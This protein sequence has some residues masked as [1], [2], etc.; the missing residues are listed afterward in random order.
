MWNP[1]TLPGLVIGATTEI[2]RALLALPGALADLERRLAQVDRLAEQSE[3]MTQL[4]EQTKA[5]AEGIRQLAE[6]ILQGSMATRDMLD[7]TQRELAELNRRLEK[8][9]AEPPRP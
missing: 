7:R 3:V 2:V 4:L 9:L 8:L 5:T 6:P 1:L